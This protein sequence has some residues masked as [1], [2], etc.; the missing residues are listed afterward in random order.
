MESL[1]NISQIFGYILPIVGV[2]VLIALIVLLINVIKIVKGLNVTVGKANITVDG[3]NEAV[4]TTNGYLKDLNTTVKTVNNMAMSVEAVRATTERAVKRSTAA[5]SK[6]YNQ[7]KGYV[8]D[9]LEKKG[10]G[11]K[12][13][14]TVTEAPAVKTTEPNIE[15]VE[16]TV[17]E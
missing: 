3:V 6:Q 15:T 9:F 8:L 13:E 5:W 2:C 1:A 10:P 11:K 17:A 16:K 7:V 12:P 4:A 14:V